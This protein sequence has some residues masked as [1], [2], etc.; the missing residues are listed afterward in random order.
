L[1][2]VI[3]WI[4]PASAADGAEAD[5]SETEAALEKITRQLNDLN[6]WLGSAERK[7][8]QWQREIQ[9]SDREVASLSR[10]VDAAAEAL[11]QVGAEQQRL[12]AE[13]AE[14]NEQRRRQARHIADHLASAY[15]M[16]GED[17]VKLLLNQQSPQTVDRMVRYHRYFTTARMASLDAYRSTLEQLEQNSLRLQERAAEAEEHQARLRQEQNALVARR[18]ERRV[19]LAR[20]D[21]EAKDKEA[22]R[23]RLIEDRERL[24]T[25]LAELKRRAQAL[26]GRAFADRKGS[27]PWPVNGRV[28]NAFGQTRTEGRLVWHGLLVA[29]DEGTPVTAVFRG[30]VVFADWL[31][32]FGLLTIVDHGSG[33]MTLYGHADTLQKKVGDWVESGEVIAR[34][35]RSGGVSTTGLYFEVRQDGRATDPI[36]WLAKR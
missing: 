34:A 26:D 23:K 25:L 29:A 3:A 32:G 2:V 1:L 30:R 21:A 4:P 35:G 18:E 13:Q 9:S 8:A 33:Y 22:E 11:A 31:R 16:S 36:T 24:E 14:L 17:F 7:R 15:R 27:L 6:V 12:Q 20:L 10:Q 28:Q 5:R 19:L